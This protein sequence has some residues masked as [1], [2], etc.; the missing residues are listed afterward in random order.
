MSFISESI[1]AISPGLFR[2]WNLP[3]CHSQNSSAY[4]A[5][6]SYDGCPVWKI[7]VKKVLKPQQHREK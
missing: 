1:I 4:G 5:I 6:D 3:V 2:P 7:K